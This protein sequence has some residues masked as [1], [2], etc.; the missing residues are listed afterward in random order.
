MKQ[1]TVPDF[2]QFFGWSMKKLTQFDSMPWPWSL[3]TNWQWQWR[4]DLCCLSLEAKSAEK[5]LEIRWELRVNWPPFDFCCLSSEAKGSDLWKPDLCS[6][7]GNRLLKPLKN[8]SDKTILP[9]KTF[10]FLSRMS[11][12]RSG[13]GDLQVLTNVKH[14]G[15]TKIPCS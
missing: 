4:P 9:S 5:W 2:T 13:K 3:D 7:G 10:D 6:G 11:S 15:N 1:F 12:F 14:L 8:F